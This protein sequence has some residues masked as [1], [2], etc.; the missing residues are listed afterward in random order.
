MS[1]RI[2]VLLVGNNEGT[3]RDY[4]TTIREAVLLLLLYYLN[5]EGE[6]WRGYIPAYRKPRVLFSAL[7]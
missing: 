1:L 7:L 5:F 4:T 2:A 3:A 6:T